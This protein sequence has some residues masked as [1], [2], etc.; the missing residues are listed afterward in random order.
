[1]KKSNLKLR[2]FKLLVFIAMLSANNIKAQCNAPSVLP[3]PAVQYG[4]VLVIDQSNTMY[5]PMMESANKTSSDAQVAVNANPC[6]TSDYVSCVGNVCCSTTVQPGVNGGYVYV[7]I[8]WNNLNGEL[9][10]TGIQ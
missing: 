1:M 10:H 8:C 7:T 6:T 2:V 5:S 3:F 9:L 4:Q